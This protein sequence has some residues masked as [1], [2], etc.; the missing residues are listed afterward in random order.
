MW[1]L[2]RR[3]KL[4]CGKISAAEVMCITASSRA[5]CIRLV[6]YLPMRDHSDLV[7]VNDGL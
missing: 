3:S 7:L 6:C 4:R 5:E 1:S 2:E